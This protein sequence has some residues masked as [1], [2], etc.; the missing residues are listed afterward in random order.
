MVVPNSFILSDSAAMDI[1]SICNNSNITA[2]KTVALKDGGIDQWVC[3]GLV[4]GKLQFQVYNACRRHEKI[5]YLRYNPDSL[6]I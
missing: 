4:M 5:R 1:L 3:T 6:Y 2:V